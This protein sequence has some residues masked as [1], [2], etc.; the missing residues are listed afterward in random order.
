MK[1]SLRRAPRLAIVALALAAALAAPDLGARPGGGQSFKAPSRPSSPSSPSRPSSPSSPSRPSSPSSP[2]RPSSP[3]SPSRPSSPSWP[4]SPSHPSSP[5]TRSPSSSDG[6][7]SSEGSSA[8]SSGDRSMTGFFLIMLLLVAVVVAILVL[9]SRA[10]SGLRGPEWE[11]TARDLD[12][13]ERRRREHVRAYGS[14]IDALSAIREHDPEFSFV[15]FEDFVYA[16]YAETHTARGAGKL[17]ALAPYLGRRTREGLEVLGF[18]GGR[19]VENVIVGSMRVERVEVGGIVAPTAVVVQFEANYAEVE[20]Q[21]QEHAYYTAERWTLTRAAGVK[22]RPPARARIVDCP[23]CGAPLDKIIGGTC[24]Y[25]QKDVSHG[26]HDWVVQSIEILSREERPPFLT[27]TVEEVG[28]NDPTI[29]APDVKARWTALVEKDPS[30]DW[31]AFTA[32]IELCFRTFH[33]GWTKQDL[34]LVRAFLSDNLFQTQLYWVDAYK[35][36]KLRN[37]TDGSRIVA[38]HLCRVVSDA[39]FDAVTVRVFAT[40]LDYTVNEAGEVVSGNNDRERS[41]SEYW[42]LIRGVDRTGAPRTTPAC[43]SCGAGLDVSMA[44]VCRYCSAKITTGEFDWV[45][46]RIEQDEVYG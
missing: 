45:L 11:S 10:D 21:G 46:S 30:L 28:T 38:I 40:G 15:L 34:K 26:E 19:T 33:E 3:S 43:P 25:C 8:R 24:G 5:S 7:S 23:N 42:T 32:R 41:Y 14:L 2:S 27:G 31:G 22:S 35:R 1:P 9:L 39:R 16:L 12:D 6:S 29:V 20:T 37:L 13:A 18:G 17:D 36:Q 44:G 4:S